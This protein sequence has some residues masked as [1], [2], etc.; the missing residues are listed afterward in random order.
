MPEL[1]VVIVSWNVRDLL[2]A[3]LRSLFADVQQSGLAAQVWVVDNGSA[4]G[5]PDMV[6]ETFPAVHLIANQENLG[7][8]RANNRALR[9]LQGSEKRTPKYVWLLNPDTEVLPGATA[10]LLSALTADP[11]VGMVGPKLVYADGS[12]QHSAF[13]FPGLIQLL[14]DLFPLPA[15]LYDTPLNGRYPRRLY[16]GVRPF[17]V[18]FPLG[19]S[20]MVKSAAIADVGLMDESFFMYCEEIDWCWRMRKASWHITCVPA[21]RVVHH[22]GQSSGQVRIPSFINL[23]TSRAHLYARH[24]RPLTRRLARILVRAGMK[25]RKRTAPPEM[26]D[27]CQQVIEIWKQAL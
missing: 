18:D 19:A 15:R 1:A 11:Q 8:V 21:A 5:T 16:E 6:A 13:R 26:V 9:K 3:C 22:A 2:A 20:M 14:F 7:F 10:A 23:W 24:H 17:R 27:A 12:L 25:R 4:D